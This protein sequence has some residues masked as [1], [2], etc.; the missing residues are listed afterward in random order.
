M[1]ASPAPIRVFV[2]YSHKDKAL[3]EKLRAHISLLKRRG[4]IDDWHDGQ[5]AA[6]Q[7][8]A[9]EID[10]NLASA[11][12]IL[13]L[14]SADFLAS[15]YC[16]SREME[17][18]LQRHDAGEARVIPVI[19]R[20]VDWEDAPFAR[21]QALPAGGRPVRSWPDEDEAFS[22]IAKWPSPAYTDTVTRLMQPLGTPPS[23]APG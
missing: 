17:N 4:V 8:W 13:L 22:D 2:S 9:Q 7:A 10:E 20:E 23:S 6:G 14:V 18:A 19:L 21:L 12:I 5:I 1:N 15:D 16:Y 11:A 3:L